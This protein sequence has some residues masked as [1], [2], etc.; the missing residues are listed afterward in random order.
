MGPGKNESHISYFAKTLQQDDEKLC[1]LDVLGL[2]DHPMGDQ[3]MVHEEFKESLQRNP[4]GSYI[5]CLPWKAVHP[6][7]KD[8]ATSAKARLGRLLKKI[9]FLLGA[10]LQ[11]HLNT[12]EQNYP[13]TVAELRNDLY[14]DDV[15]SGG[16]CEQEV[17]KIKEEA[18]EIFD[19]G[20][21]TLHKWHC[22]VVSL[23]EPENNDSE[24]TYAKESLG[25]KTAEARMLG[26]KWNK[27]K[28]T[29]AVDFTS[30]KA[31]QEYTKRGILRAMAKVYDPLGM[32][33]PVMLEAKHKPN[34]LR[35]KITMG[36]THGK[37]D[38]INL[39]SVAKEI[40]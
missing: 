33:S 23:E 2:Q 39:A 17:G 24:Q 15:I 18:K 22:S 40:A 14:V 31:T 13:G 36:C 25:T 10:T 9:P 6:P 28:N 20:S 7:L 30:C 35:E 1:N 38:G 5:T 8:N 29:L 12:L 11:E 37:G 19:Q 34:C 21:F 27:L 3:N 26:L 32:V 16:T 4:D